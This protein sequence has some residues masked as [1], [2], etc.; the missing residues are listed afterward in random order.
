VADQEIRRQ[1]PDS[2]EELTE[3]PC[4]ASGEDTSSSIQPVGH[5]EGYS[6]ATLSVFFE[7]C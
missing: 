3:S 5:W 4:R 2:D 7:N 1:L 6:L